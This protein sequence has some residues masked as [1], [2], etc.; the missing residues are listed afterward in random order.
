MNDIQTPAD[1]S[2]G[3]EDVRVADAARE[4]NDQAEQA[5]PKESASEPRAADEQAA[6]DS[7]AEGNADEAESRSQKRRR[8]RREALEAIRKEAE[9]RAAEARRATETLERI[10]KAGE[11]KKPPQPGDFE[12][13]DDYIAARAVHAARAASD[14]DRTESISAEKAAAERAAKAAQ[15]RAAA[16]AQ[17]IFVEAAQE[18][19]QKYADFDAVVSNPAVPISDSLAQMIVFSDAPAELAYAVAKDRALAGKL[20]AMN[21]IEAARELGR[22]EARLTAPK[23][24][25][26]T[27]APEPITP[28]KGKA[29]AARDP[30]KMTPAEFDRWRAEGGTFNL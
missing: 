26:E 17:A 20:S 16:E 23:P 1:A 2:V 18:A 3:D 8:E 30:L 14:E 22:L 13:Y 4:V 10:R 9:E 6:P 7:D 12:N 19:R 5:E 27:K 11:A 29:G 25:I 21:P 15:Q 24:R 28:V